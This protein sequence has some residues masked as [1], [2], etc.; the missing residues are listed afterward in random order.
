MKEKNIITLTFDDGSEKE[1]E[2]LFTYTLE[3]TGKKYVFVYDPEADLNSVLE[4]VEK[5][6]SEGEIL[7]IDPTDEDLWDELEEILNDYADA[8]ENVGGCAG[9]P[10]SCSGDCD[11]CDQ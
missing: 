11:G 7:P 9:C 1:L 8:Q 3:Q 2:I 4:Y 10:G 5:G 6:D